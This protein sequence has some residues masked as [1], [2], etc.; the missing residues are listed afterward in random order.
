MKKSPTQSAILDA[1]RELFARHGYRG[2]SVRAITGLAGVNLGA[3]AYHF[4]SKQGLFEAVTAT[5]ARAARERIVAAARTPGSPLRRIEAVV[6]AFFEHLYENPEVPRLVI[7]TMV[8][9]GPVPDAAHSMLG[10]NLRTL[11]QLIAEG[12]ADGSIRDGDPQ[13]MA[14]SVAS[15]PLWLVVAGRLL[16]EGMPVNQEDAATRAELVESVVAFVRA[17]LSSN[18]ETESCGRHGSAHPQSGEEA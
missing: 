10:D 16:R 17:G 5:V 13:L 1:A 4:G 8:T 18:H 11:A 14:L 12:Q 2:A 7:H 9:G 3:V 15:Q 6:R